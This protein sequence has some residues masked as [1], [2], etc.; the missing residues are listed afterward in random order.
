MTS[1]PSQPSSSASSRSILGK[2]P[3]R[4]LLIVPFV[5]QI[6]T[7]VGLTGYLSYRNGQRAVN[8]LSLQ[9]RNQASDR[10]KD[11]LDLYLATPHQINE[12][13]VQ[14][15]EQEMIDVKDLRGLGRFF[16][17]QLK[18]FNEFGY[19]NFG[20]PQGDFIG[21][22]RN[23][24]DNSLRMDFI[25]QAY[26]GEFHGYATDNR[27]FPTQ[28]IIV[29]EFDF[30]VDSWYT[31]AI[32]AKRPIWSEIYNWNDDPSVMSV[33]ASYPLYDKQQKLIGVI[34]I[35]YVLS[36]IADFLRQLQI[37]PAAKVFVIERD[38]LLVA[39]SSQEKFYTL[40]GEEA[41]RLSGL[42]SKDPTIKATTEY[43][44]NRAGGLKGIGDR[45]LLDLEIAGQKNYVQVT[46]WQDRYGLDWLIVLAVPESDFMEQIQ[47]NNQMTLALSV[48]AFG[49]AVLLGIYTSRWISRPIRRLSQASAAIA[50]GDLGQ[51]VEVKGTE[52]L[53]GLAH[54]FNQMAQQLQTSF[55]ALEQSNELLETRVEERTVELLKAKEKAEVA[56]RAKTD[57]LSQISHEL[58][59][60]LNGILGYTQILKRSPGQSQRLDEGLNI[61]HQSGT[62]LLTLINDIL[63]LAKIEAQKMELYPTALNFPAF[64]E[65]VVGII[66]ARALEKDILLNYEPGSELPIGVAADDKRLRQVLLN[67]LGNAVKFTDHG[68]ITFRVTAITVPDAEIASPPLVRFEVTDTGVGIAPEQLE[69]IFQPF[70]QVGDLQSRATGTGLGLAIAAQLVKLMGGELQ[71]ESKLDRGSTFWFE[72]P[73]PPAEVLVDP[74]S[75]RLSQVKGYTGNRRQILVV[76]DKLENRL[77]L[78]NM[79]QPL[80]FEITLAENGQQEVD[81]ALEI[82]PDLILTDLVMPI[83]SGFEAVQA[84][85]QLPEIQATPVIAVSASVFDINR[86]QCQMAGFEAFLPK[87]IDQQRLLDLLEHYLRLE[88]VYDSTLESSS[89][90]EEASPAELI[91]PPT[92]ELEVL[93]ELAMLG[94]MRKIR[95]HAAYLEE[96]DARYIPFA[97]RLQDLAYGFQEKAITSLVKKYLHW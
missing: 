38:G 25:E 9:L 57:F 63:D 6:C 34:G 66:R 5:L 42:D 36:G 95:E 20:N 55:T 53:R 97:N 80:G 16:W 58:R 92:A 24:K 62:H 75:D 8:D 86:Q 96:L 70:E 12:L 67:L 77:V 87:P 41:Q 76:D 44:I 74:E 81:L 61:I 69:K 31:D 73:L 19:I 28:R 17:K 33:S 51:T 40:K 83:M 68:Q 94:N 47:A 10:V 49:L 29:D 79:L 39:A 27:G 23:P 21:L 14:A 4:L 59:T 3:L 52:E 13:T 48:I 89:A 65:G 46:P 60:P 91:P 35:D 18:V 26:L 84:I 11:R 45:Q 85:R 22:Y 64:L 2:V 30:R 7:A 88:W 82:R 78:L 71:V 90:T 72:V 54:S 56:N 15:V 37:S 43:L 32:K 93:Y 1:L 50:A